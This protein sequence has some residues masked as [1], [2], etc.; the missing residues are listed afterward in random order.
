MTTI[1]TRTGKGSALTWVEADANFTNLE[2]AIETRI[3]LV[4]DYGAVGDGVTDDTAALQA[5][6]AAAAALGGCTIML[7]NNK[8]YKV[9]PSGTGS[10]IFDLTGSRGITVEGNGST[11]SAGSVSAAAPYVFLLDDVWNFACRN[12]QYT[13]SYTTLDS[14]NGGMLFV[15]QN[16]SRNIL[17]ENI[18]MTYG[19]SGLTVLGSPTVSGGRSQ[20]IRL[21]NGYFHT[22]YYPMNFQFSGDNFTGEVKTFNCGRTYF[23]YNVRNHNVKIESQQGGPH[24]DVLLKVYAGPTSSY[25]RLENIKID[26][27]TDG[28]YAGSNNSGADQGIIAIEAQQID[29]TSTPAY[30]SNIDITLRIEA[31]A[32]PTFASGVIFRKTTSA[33]A[34]DTTA[35]GHLFQG[36]TIRGQVLSWGNATQ[37]VIRLFPTA[38]GYNWTGDIATNIKVENFYSAGSGAQNAITINGQCFNANYGLILSNILTDQ[39]ITRSNWATTKA[40]EA[41]N[42]VSGSF[43]ASTGL[44]AYTPSW[45]GSTSNPT[46]GNG[47]IS[48][49]YTRTG[50]RVKGWVEVLVGST[51]VNGVGD[52]RFSLPFTAASGIGVQLGNATVLDSGTRW[53]VGTSYINT[54]GVSYATMI[55][56]DAALTFASPITPATNDTFRIEFDYIAAA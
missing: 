30:F 54:G 48:G 14:A 25:N 7:G 47:T 19:R 43:T 15:V 35:R 1:V 18:S 33:G 37:D 13:Q 27:W 36:I 49:F 53:Y 41:V 32:S 28:K 9:W 10:T 38:P 4:S 39:L 2:T 6:A 46:I 40:F 8:T 42:V 55:V 23:P 34:A 21:H 52:Q 45:T 3:L 50:D 56:N 29:S 5:C 20:N 31:V 22:V 24:D 44:T 11:I 12:L 17:L 16:G 51:T 26:Y